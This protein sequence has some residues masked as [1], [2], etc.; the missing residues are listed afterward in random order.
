MRPWAVPAYAQIEVLHE[1]DGLSLVRYRCRGEDARV[2]PD[3][4]VAGSHQFCFVQA[5]SFV[6][7]SP[8]GQVAA[9]ANQVLFFDRGGA[10]R[11]HHPQPGGDACLVLSVPDDD[12]LAWMEAWGAR[13]ERGP[14]GPTPWECGLSDGRA[15]LAAHRLVADLR[16][17]LDALE[18]HERALALLAGVRPLPVATPPRGGSR[19]QGR[20]TVEAVKLMLLRRLGDPL[21][22]AEIA[23]HFGLS[24]F[25]LCRLFHRHAG[26]PV[27]R[28]RRRLRLR[29][30]LA[31]LADGQRDLTDLALDLGFSD[32]S[33]FTNAFREEFDAPP[34]AFRRVLVS[35][36]RDSSPVSPPMHPGARRCSSVT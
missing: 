7:R 11:V 23:G 24:P 32:H 34:S 16:R 14:D 17:G 22:L 1:G 28:Y 6:R 10:Y 20:E 33:H 8:R 13:P 19:R 31:R 25:T 4:E 36:P 2:A 18:T 26:L 21:R 30:A 35:R 15:A 5:G 29:H 9:D 27:H 12:R 3:E